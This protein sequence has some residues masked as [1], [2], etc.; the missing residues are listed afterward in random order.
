MLFAFFFAC[1]ARGEALAVGDFVF[2]AGTGRESA[3]IRHASDS[4][5]SH[6]GV[7]VAIAPQVQIVHATT[8]DDPDHVNQVILSSYTAFAAPHLA[9][10][11]AV[12]RPQFLTPDARQK[13]ADALRAQ[14]GQPFV[15]TAREKSPRYCTTI[16]FDALQPLQP[17]LP[18]RWQRTDLPLFAGEY[19]FPQAFAELP[20]LY[21]LESVE[22]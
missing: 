16:V 14:V 8:D 18:L 21:W 13:L 15:L 3:L 7:V 4:A 12:A 5:W 10:R 2:R 6:M 1:T 20:D 19:L 22:E 17:D 11:I 9:E